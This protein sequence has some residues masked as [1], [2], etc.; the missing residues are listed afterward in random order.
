MHPIMLNRPSVGAFVSDISR[1]VLWAQLVPL[2]SCESANE[3]E[4]TCCPEQL[5]K[6]MLP[7]SLSAAVKSQLCVI[8]GFIMQHDE[9]M[10]N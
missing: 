3:D 2:R 8:V 6:P 4:T 1:L 9:N 10:G 5:R 7:P